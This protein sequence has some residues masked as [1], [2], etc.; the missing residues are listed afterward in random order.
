MEADGKQQLAHRI[1][2][3]VVWLYPVAYLV[4]T[5]LTLWIYM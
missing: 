3:Y 4:G 5:A 2:A 1:D